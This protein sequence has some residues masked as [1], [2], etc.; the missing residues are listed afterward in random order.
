MFSGNKKLNK[1]LDSANIKPRATEAEISRLAWST[2]PRYS[3]VLGVFYCEGNLKPAIFS[4]R[5]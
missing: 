3:F 4:K 2:G 5:F 1:P